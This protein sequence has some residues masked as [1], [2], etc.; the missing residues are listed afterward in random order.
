MDAAGHI[1]SVDFFKSVIRSKASLT[2]AEAQTLL[3]SPQPDDVISKS[4]NDLNRLAKIFRQR[5]IDTGALTLA[6][7]EV[8]T[9]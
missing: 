5:R 7:P 6:S 1:V 4:V 8:R 9:D 3:D 2:Y